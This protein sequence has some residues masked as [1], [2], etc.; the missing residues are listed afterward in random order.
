V[1]TARRAGT[2]RERGVPGQLPAAAS[3]GLAALGR[4]ALYVRAWRAGDRIRPLGMKGSRKLQDVFVD[5]KIPAARRGR[6]PV[7]ECGGEIVWVAGYRVAAGWEVP[8]GAPRA[9][10]VRVDP[11]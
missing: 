6:I 8:D 5:A 7:F 11:A 9:L 1:T 2:A 4:K 10:Q 3:L